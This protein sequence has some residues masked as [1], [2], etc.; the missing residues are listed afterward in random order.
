MLALRA[1]HDAVGRAPRRRPVGPPT[2]PRQRRRWCSS[3]C[4][5]CGVSS[6]GDDAQ[7]L[8]HGRGYELRVADG[9]VDAA[10]FERLVDGHRSH[11]RQRLRTASRATPLGSGA[12]RP[13]PTS[14]ASRSRRRRSVVSTS[15]VSGRRSLRS[16]A[17]WRH[18]APRRCSPELERLVE[19]HPLRERLHEQR[20][21]ALIARDARPRPSRLTPPHAAGS[22]TRSASSRAT[23]CASCRR[24][25]CARTRHCN[26][27]RPGG[28]VAASPRPRA[29]PGTPWRRRGAGART[30]AADIAF[31]GACSPS[32]AFAVVFVAWLTRLTGPG[33][34]A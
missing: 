26:S 1:Q 16:R 25:S 23:S 11:A 32:Q 15:C 4:R 13:W 8:T 20:M 34:R 5:S 10:R 7:I 19:Q 2:R 3:T 28:R 27:P 6:T 14:R 24:G 22:S 29:R 21:L 9:A 31:A 18:G 30:S 33:R 12:G 17:I